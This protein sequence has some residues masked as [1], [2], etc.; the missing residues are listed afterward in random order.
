MKTDDWESWQWQLSNSIRNLEDLKK[1]LN[2]LEEEKIENVSNE[3]KLSSLSLKITPYY[4]DLIKKNP[5]LRRTVVPTIYEF[6]HSDVESVDPLFEEQYRKT[7]CIIQK[8]PNR[9]LFTI[10]KQCASYCRYCTRSRMV[11]DNK[12]FNKED[13]NDAFE[14]IRNND[15]KDVLL[16]GGDALM[17]TNLQLEFLLSKLTDIPNVDIIRIG[18]KIPVTLPFR[19]DS[20]LIEILKRYNEIKPIYVNIHVTHP[21]EITTEFIESCNNL[22]IESNCILGSQTVI[23]KG[24]ND[25]A[26]ILKEL[27]HKLLKNRIKPYYAYQMDKIIGGSHFRIDIEKFIDLQ[28]QL[29]SYNSGLEVPDFIIDSEIGKIPLRLDYVKRENGKYI[30]TSFEKNKSIEY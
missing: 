10:T 25:D 4:L 5:I 1:E 13:W 30:L 28:K 8:Y 19:V 17:L 7:A 20:G 23:L 18:T 16:S 22:S 2:L 24:I 9:V 12:N 29:L 21:S 26:Q 11:G 27:F 3:D 15:I 6:E 14:Y